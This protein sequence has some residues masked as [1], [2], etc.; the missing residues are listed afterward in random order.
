MK[1][2]TIEYSKN[3]IINS[4]DLIRDD[5]CDLEKKDEALQIIDN[6]RASHAYPLHV[7]YS[8][9]RRNYAN[10]DFIVAERLKRLNSIVDKLNREPH[11]N[12]WRMQ[13]LG[14]CR[15]IAP[16]IDDVYNVVNN[17]KKSNVRHIFKREY[18]Y[19]RNP[20]ASGYRG[21]HLVYQYCSDKKDTFNRNMNIEIQIRSY[22]QHLWA[23]AVEA[24]GIF[25]KQALKAGK[26]KDEMLRFFSLVSS[27]LALDEG[28]EQVPETP[29][30]KEELIEEIK[31]LDKKYNILAF[32]SGIRAGTLG[33]EERYQNQK[34]YYILILNYDSR[35]LK[36]KYFKPSQ[37]DEATSVYNQIEKTSGADMVDAV[38]VYIASINQL[39][40]AYPN[41]FL[42]ITEFIEIVNRFL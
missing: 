35:M 12:L 33:I 34:G 5:S 6:W 28:T 10:N 39:K 37:I 3:Q 15:I 13:D 31:S 11:M 4:G 8:Y 30:D 29:W 18:D 21:I 25:T 14:G 19:I 2:K 24:M 42:N 26:G 20:K 7:I 40:A 23:T 16:S 32:L 36:L 9:F 1:W 22:K 27:L 38:L 17:Y 41:Y